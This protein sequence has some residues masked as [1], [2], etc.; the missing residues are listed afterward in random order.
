MWK[1]TALVMGRREVSACVVLPDMAGLDAI[2]G[3]A[4][5]RSTS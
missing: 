4:A 3:G 5:E 1:A 2:H